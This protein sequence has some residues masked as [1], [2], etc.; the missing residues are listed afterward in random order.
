[1]LGEAVELV[2]E[3]HAGRYVALLPK[4]IDHLAPPTHLG[5][6]LLPARVCNHVSSQT[7]KDRCVGHGVTHKTRQQLVR[8]DNG[9]LS[10]RLRAL[11]VHSLSL[12]ARTKCVPMGGGG[13]EDDTLPVSNGAGCEAT[14]G[15]VEKL[16]ILVKLYDVIARPR[17]R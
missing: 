5:I 4:N 12:E 17:A 6:P 15:A 1:M 11:H 8:V 16:L 9:Q 14:N 2:L 13:H 7:E 10:P 3:T